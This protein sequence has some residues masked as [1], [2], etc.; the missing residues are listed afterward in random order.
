MVLHVRPRLAW[1]LLTLVLAAWA[2]P[3]R[4]LALEG[5]PRL[6]VPIAKAG[7]TD[8][9]GRFRQIFCT[10]LTR[11]GPAVP[12]FRP[13]EQA[14]WRVGVEPPAD[15]RPVARG[16]IRPPL[17]LVLVSGYGA[18]CF[19]RL[20]RLFDEAEAHVRRLD[21]AVVRV[22]VTAF[23]SV[24]QNAAII[25]RTLE[26]LPRDGRRLVLLGYSKG[27]ADA[28]AALVRHPGTARRVDA[29]IT[30]AGAIGGSPLAEVVPGWIETLMDLLPGTRC[31]WGDRGALADLRPDARLA[32]LAR[33]P[34]PP[35][36]PLVISLAAFAPMRE[37]SNLLQPFHGLLARIDR[38][39]DGMLLW[40]DQLVPG[41]VLA[42]Y[43]RGDH[44][45]VA[46][47]IVRRLPWLVLQFDRNTYP[48]TALLEAILRFTA[49]RLPPP[50][51][52][53]GPP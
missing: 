25:A 5:P 4:P 41:G 13:C 12:G 34:T 32:A 19:S 47:P 28:M 30:L 44:L 16:P 6:T 36:V 21:V 37:T 40:T 15:D 14:L 26:T 45:A 18:Q 29:L 43:L 33:W 20:V 31:A 50:P 1:L 51:A 17:R 38:R 27:A 23:G 3:G 39:N 22:P 49:E 9:R 46:M 24:A 11:E 52:A 35:P 53:D 7:I 10:V 2:G 8:G 42:A 48:R